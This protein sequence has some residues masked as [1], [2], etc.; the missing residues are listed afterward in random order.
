M[1]YSNKKN[2]I[3]YNIQNF[4]VGI[5]PILSIAIFSRIFSTSDFG[6][7]ALAMVFGNI[8]SSIINF[9]LHFA[10]E[11][12]YFRINNQDEKENLFNSLF[13][14]NIILFLIFLIPIKYFQN[15]ISYLIFNSS[16][17]AEFI[18]VSYIA[19]NLSFLN[20]FFL[21]KTRNQKDGKK[22]SLI[23][24]SIVSIQFIISII[25]V[26]YLEFKI[27]GLIYAMLFSNLII[28]SCLI[29]FMIN[30]KKI[31]DIKILKKALIFSYPLLPKLLVGVANTSYDKFIIK[32]LVS[33][34]GLGIYDLS[35][36]IAFQ[37]NNFFSVLQSTFLPDFYK[38]ANESD[39]FEKKDL[40]LFIT[41]Y[42]FISSLFCLI[43][44]FFSYELI[45]IITPK[46]FHDAINLIS[47]LSLSYS[48]LFFGYVPIL[49]HLKK[50]FLISKFSIFSFLFNLIIVISFINV[51]GLIGAV[52]GILISNL[53]TQVIYFIIVYRLFPL[54]W[55][56]KKILSIYFLLFFCSFFIIMIR[57]IQIY[58]FFRI[59]IKIFFIIFFV[60][61]GHYKKILDLQFYYNLGINKLSK[62]KAK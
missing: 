49:V 5:I 59:L 34:G 50:T 44:S 7:F 3:F 11:S 20:S 25:L 22:N 47:I 48:L 19:S 39:V 51:F 18:L 35:Q 17:N 33:L 27:E 62:F 58:Y 36:R 10:Y 15:D 54:K 53:I 41:K 42:F 9:G 4:Y 2:F 14:F 29:I 30:N 6:I 23:K 12:F 56:L 37:I 32:L 55:D 61:Y 1:E 21:F 28:L 46:S 60:Y 24:I 52:V 40:P 8:C 31:F 43:F 16:E 13:Y 57:E 26:F 45:S 38:M